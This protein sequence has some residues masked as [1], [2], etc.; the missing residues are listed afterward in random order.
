M[1]LHGAGISE[2][3]ERYFQLGDNKF[4]TTQDENPE[5]DEHE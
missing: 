2:D 1:E 5:D 3:I 4:L